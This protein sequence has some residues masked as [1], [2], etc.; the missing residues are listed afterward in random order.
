MSYAI[1]KWKVEYDKEKELW[2]ASNHE[3]DEH[4]YSENRSYLVDVIKQIGT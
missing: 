4:L 3:T 2:H 1:G